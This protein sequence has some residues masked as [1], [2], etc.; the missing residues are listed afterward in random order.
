MGAIANS[1]SP[2][3]SVS[4]ALQ[5]GCDLP[6]VC[7][8]AVEHLEE[9]AAAIQLLPDTL[10]SDV[11]RRITRFRIMLSTFAPMRFIEWRDYLKDA[12]AF[13]TSVPEV[14]PS[15]PSSPVFDY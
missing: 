1:Y 7:H 12:S 15:A 4:L 10:L 2:A 14:D 5:A 3:Q 9:I 6:L 8:N 13:T 11:E